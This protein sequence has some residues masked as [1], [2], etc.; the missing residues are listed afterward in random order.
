VRPVVK[1][2]LTVLLV[3]LMELALS[4]KMVIIIRVAFVPLVAI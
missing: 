4:V 2:I 3:I 1:R